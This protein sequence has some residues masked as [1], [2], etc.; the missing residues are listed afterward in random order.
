MSDE[1]SQPLDD[2][3]A[4][5]SRILRARP[6]GPVARHLA[7]GARDEP[8]ARRGRGLRLAPPAGGAN[9]DDALAEVID[10][11]AHGAAPFDTVRPSSAPRV[12]PRRLEDYLPGE[13]VV[14]QR[15]R[16][17]LGRWEFDDR[18]LEAGEVLV[19]L[20]AWTRSGERGPML[21]L[22]LETTGFA[23][24]PLFL[25]GFVEIGAGDVGAR[26]HGARAAEASEAVVPGATQRSRI[27]QLFARDYS[28]E[29]AVVE[30]IAA[31]LARR[32]TLVTFNGKSYDLPFLRDRAACHRV[33]LPEPG[34]HFDLLHAARKRWKS[35][36][37]NC[38][39]ATLEAHM[40]GGYG[41]IADVSGAEIPSRYHDAVR[42]GD[43]SGLF[44]VF[45][46]NAL[47][48]VTLAR[49]HL[50]LA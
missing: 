50:A 23:G 6:A 20:D 38:R 39:L 27:T 28:E 37:P 7:H 2:L 8:A 25:A 29:A 48:L 19:E 9:D 22:D 17:W 10:A 34:D 21:L 44:G 40:G 14:G 41:R 31:R 36:L 15:G 42:R 16:C 49:L 13:E 35:I 32:P 33:A 24:T 1:S 11:D 3:R 45:L 30:A 26:E 46:H 47:D 43:P 12:R 4:R 18:A 5:L